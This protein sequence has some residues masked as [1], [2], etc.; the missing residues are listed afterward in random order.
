MKRFAALAALALAATTVASTA[1]F[2]D[3][4]GPT[5]GKASVETR[6]PAAGELTVD[7]VP[8]RRHPT[9]TAPVIKV[10]HY[11]RPDYR[12]QEIYAVASRDGSDGAPWYRISVP[13][14]PNGTYGW[15]P[16]STV[17]LAPT[18]GQIVVNVQARTIDVYRG[19]RHALHASVAVGAPG[20]PTPLGHY[21]VA[22]RFVPY[23]DPFLGVFAVETSAFSSLTEW[24]GGGVV[25][26][27]GTDEPWLIG[28]AVSHGCVRVSNQTAA[29]LR[30]LA[31]L[32]TPIWI[33]A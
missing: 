17:E 27:H 19:E 32:G 8:V 31:P 12:V 18:V 3:G 16:A 24:P 1:A 6:F 15:I 5:K 22:A 9:P 26:I 33:K 14:R 10:M 23:H 4:M 2:A 13:M 30:R 7:S 29:A 11:F 21:Y 20:M 25:G 28:R